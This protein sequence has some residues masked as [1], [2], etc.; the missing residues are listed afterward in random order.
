MEFWLRAEMKQEADV[1]VAYSQVI[2]K[3]TLGDWRKELG[4]LYFDSH[5]LLDKKVD[6]KAANLDATVH[7]LDRYLR[8]H[9]Q[10]MT[11]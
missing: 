6:P 10:P 9:A 5:D 11:R 4:G 3:L 2:E 1:Q 8:S 7:D